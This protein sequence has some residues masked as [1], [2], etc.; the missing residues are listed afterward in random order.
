MLLRL[1]DSW[2][3]STSE[4]RI[5]LVSSLLEVGVELGAGIPEQD[6]VFDS[7]RW[8]AGEL[9]DRRRTASSGG[10]D[11][12]KKDGWRGRSSDSEARRPAV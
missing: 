2:T 7:E 10:A 3:S 12:D 5:V 6:F 8:R 9:Q 11:N 1:P 4:S